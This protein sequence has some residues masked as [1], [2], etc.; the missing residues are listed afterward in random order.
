MER[1]QIGGASI[2]A[3][4]EVIPGI[5]LWWIDLDQ[6]HDAEDVLAGDEQRRASRFYFDIDRRRFVAAHN[7]LRRILAIYAGVAPANLAFATGANGKPYL[8]EYPNIEFSLS[9][10]GSV[11]G[12][13]AST[14]GP[15]GFDCEQIKH[16][17]ERDLPWRQVCS[18]EELLL[19]AARDPEARLDFFYKI[20]TRKEAVLKA[21]GVGISFPLR[22]LTVISSSCEGCLTLRIPVL[23]SWQV[24]SDFAPLGYEAA[25]CLPTSD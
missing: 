13:V 4:K 8:I 2:L 22:N 11:A 14:R 23:G 18:K 7:S 3:S 17:E 5:A 19:V 1:R 21:L 24:C 10:S 16:I 6:Q 15:V 25:Y 20:W 9:H 12:L